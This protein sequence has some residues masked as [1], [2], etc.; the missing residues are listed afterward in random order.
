MRQRIVALAC[1][2][3]TLSSEWKTSPSVSLTVPT[4]R[5]R[6]ARAHRLSRW[7][8]RS[9]QGST[10]PRHRSWSC[11]PSIFSTNR[12]CE[13]SRRPFARVSDS[14]RA[15]AQVMSD[16]RCKRGHTMIHS[17]YSGGGYTTGWHVRADALAF[18]ESETLVPAP[19]RWF[20]HFTF[21]SFLFLCSAMA[22]ARA[23]SRLS[24]AWFAFRAPTICATTVWQSTS[25]MCVRACV[26]CVNAR[27][28]D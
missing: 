17:T 1:V 7:R 5:R 21:F 19:V 24:L 20:F 16:L 4:R 9:R 12:T 25:T 26:L 22:V 2:R 28:N 18:A 11:R 10:I 6:S 15:L 3:C 13:L 14:A 27:R 8:L 23:A